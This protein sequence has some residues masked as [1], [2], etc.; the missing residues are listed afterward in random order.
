MAKHIIE[1]VNTIDEH[2]NKE[3]EELLQTLIDN[4]GIDKFIAEINK[5][6]Y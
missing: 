3:A 1:I 2:K 6:E 4:L 5:I